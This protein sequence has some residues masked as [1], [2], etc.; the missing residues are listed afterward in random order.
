MERHL[1]RLARRDIY[2][3]EDAGHWWVESREG[4][5]EGRVRTYEFDAEEPAMD[6]VS[7]L[8]AQP[9]SG[10]SCAER[11]RGGR[12]RPGGGWR[13]PCCTR[14]TQRIAV[15][16]AYQTRKTRQQA[17]FRNGTLSSARLGLIA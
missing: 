13:Q 4:G 15:R 9:G 5:A 16:W 11:A 6:C 14:L 17:I 12:R 8:L 7:G 1:G 3:F 10:G 2:L